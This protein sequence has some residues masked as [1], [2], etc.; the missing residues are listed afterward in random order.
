MDEKYVVLF[1]WIESEKQYEISLRSPENLSLIRSKRIV[2]KAK[3][4]EGFHYA[5]GWIALGASDT[6]IRQ[7]IHLL[8]SDSNY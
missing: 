1:C 2:T 7:T 8:N 6:S 3:I 5:N 4:R